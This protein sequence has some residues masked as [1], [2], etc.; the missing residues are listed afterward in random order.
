[1]T[2]TEYVTALPHYDV[3]LTNSFQWYIQTMWRPRSSI[4]AAT[5]RYDLEETLAAYNPVRSH[6]SGPPAS[7]KVPHRHITEHFGWVAE[8]VLCYAIYLRADRVAISGSGDRT[9]VLHRIVRST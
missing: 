5:W 1:M 8:Y 7:P 2:Q 9:K 6:L 4:G 3:M